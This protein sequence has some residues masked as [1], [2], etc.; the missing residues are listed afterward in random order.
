MIYFSDELSHYGVRGMKWGVRKQQQS[1]GGRLHRLAAANYGL[2]ERFY[3]KLG[4]NT[5]AN[6]NAYAKKDSL[7]K[8]QAADAAKIAKRQASTGAKA[9]KKQAIKNAKTSYKEAKAKS[10]AARKRY[11]KSFNK[12]SNY[13]ALHYRRQFNKNSKAYDKSNDLWGE[14]INDAKSY[15]TAHKEMRAARKAYRQTK[16]S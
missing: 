5:A 2:N 12:A 1:M 10:A 13:S 4:N 14:A 9:A 6:M 3:R 16:R 7:K 15:N 11:N 8:A